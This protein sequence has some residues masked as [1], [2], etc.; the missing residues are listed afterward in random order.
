MVFLVFV[1]VEASP[2]GSLGR[3]DLVLMKRSAIFLKVL[4]IVVALI[5]GE[6]WATTEHLHCKRTR[7]I[8]TR[9]HSVTI[10]E[11]GAVG[12][13]VTLNTKAFQNAIFYLHSFAD[14]GG[15]QLF[16]PAGRWLTG[17]FSLISHLTLS[18]DQDAVI[19]G[20]TSSSD[21]PIIESLP[22]YGRG[23]ELPGR[24]HQS[25]INGSNLTDVIITGG[26]GTL[27]GQGGVWWQWFNNHTLN[28]TRPHLVE[29]INSTGVVIS[30]LT[31]MN[32]PF[33][34]IHP[35]YC[36]EV[37]IHDVTILAPL[38][39]PNTDGIDPD[40]SS[41]VCIEDCYI[42]TGDDVIV[43]KSGW[44]EYGIAFAHPS[45]NISI[46]RITGQTRSGA[47]IAFGS[48][49]SGG[50]S[51]VQV[52]NIHLFNS[53]HGI[54]IK[55]SPGRGG[56][57]KNIHISGVIMEDVNIAIRIQGN[58]GEHPDDNFD[59]NAL[60][61]ISRITMKDIVGTN[62]SLAGLLAG[63]PGDNFSSICMSNII[64]T[65]TSSSS[66][67]SPAWKCSDIE[68]YSDMVSPESCEQLHKDIPEDP[69]KVC[70]G[71]YDSL[72]Q[73]EHYDSELMA[74]KPDQL[75]PE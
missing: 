30:N 16:V 20:S 37:L 28:Y 67:S 9:P 70:Y 22:S 64:F 72:Q 26:N 25:L 6:S 11:F 10:T 54:R 19:I 13:G 2:S 29:L 1:F 18:L 49:M 41:N 44:D 31:F 48:E 63:I 47:G 40:S 23:R 4:L 34:A 53:K 58:Y 46:S 15:A 5:C 61:L 33:W 14:K 74:S 51:E 7:K 42:S 59:P 66:S 56:Y 43:I 73:E 68:G 36:S 8:V 52:A 65:G 45:T 60:P 38:D 12:D 24:R 32:S 35:V 62:I 21:W 69:S 71:L 39:S 55:T 27:D 50:I 75:A 3:S 57:V 17:S